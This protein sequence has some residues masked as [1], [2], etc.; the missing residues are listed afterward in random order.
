MTDRPRPPELDPTT[1]RPPD[2]VLDG[3]DLDELWHDSADAARQRFQAKRELLEAS[4]AKG[5]TQIRIDARRPGCQVP[6]TLVDEPQLVLNLSWRFAN[7][8]MVINERGIAA[9]LRFGGEPFRCVLPWRAVWGV[10]PFGEE[11]L[12]VWPVDLPFELGGPPAS[13]AG[14]VEEPAPV[15]PIRPRLSLLSNEPVP[16]VEGL[17]ADEPPVAEPAQAEHAERPRAPWLRVV[18]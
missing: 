1:P 8:E 2:V 16:A 7:T 12:R 18:K 17:E 13:A 4:L 5:K 15:E 6:A 10:S 9:T 11:K 3:L 14:A